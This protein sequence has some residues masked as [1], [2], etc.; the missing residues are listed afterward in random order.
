MASL[1]VS[2][3]PAAAIELKE[4]SVRY[5]LPHE[6]IRSIKEYAIRRMRRDL[7]YDDFWA[8]HQVSVTVQRGEA[9]GLIGPNGSGKSTLLKVVARVLRPTLGRVMVR[10]RVAPLLELGTGF[11]YELTGRE[12]V[13][14]NGA[15]LGQGQRNLQARF[16]R[17][18]D[19][20]GLW[21]FV[22]APL[23]TYST[24]MVARLGFAIATDIP[25]EILIV[26]EVL[27]VGDAE[28]RQKSSDRIAAFRSA[29]ATILLVSHSM[30]TVRQLCDRAIWLQNGQ[31]QAAGG[32]AE[33]IRRYT[34]QVEQAVGHGQS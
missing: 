21:N 6:R 11:D 28:F 12:N 17:I 7:V 10:G 30:D 15:M 4:V 18:V 13:F 29:G 5:R 25:P 1:T 27:S 34:T 2:R 22:D 26:D 31:V 9:L 24:G 19:F 32:A 33:V 3:S 23:R 20:A 16:D 14:L 8:L